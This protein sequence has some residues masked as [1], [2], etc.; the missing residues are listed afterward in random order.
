MLTT[1]L[2]FS[3]QNVPAAE[4]LR[5]WYDVF[6]QSNSR[7][8]LS[9]VCDGPFD[10][11]VTVSNLGDGAASGPVNAGVCV[12]RMA[13]GAGFSARRTGELLADGNDDVILYIQQAGRRTVSQLGRETLVEPGGGILSSNAEPSMVVVPE[14]SRFASI[15]VSR[16]PMM[17]LVPNLEDLFVRPLP[18]ASGVLQLL[19]SYLASLEHGPEMNTPQ[20]LQAVIT[21]I[22]DLVAVAAGGGDL[23][24]SRGIGQGMTRLS[25][26]SRS[27]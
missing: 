13:F 9:P 20:F 22:Y 16:K 5:S 27:H 11:D 12:Q 18:G 24:R 26:L 15:A 2:R 19:E 7:R 21:H 1:T 17:A 14:P 25:L 23:S 8:E 6:D 3:T 4:R 10:M